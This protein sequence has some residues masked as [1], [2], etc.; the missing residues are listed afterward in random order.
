M[1]E[2]DSGDRRSK[3]RHVARSVRYELIVEALLIV[4]SYQRNYQTYIIVYTRK[5]PYRF[6][7]RRPR[8]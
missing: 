1:S 3:D 2:Q 8:E 6:R 4:L 7:W 5:S